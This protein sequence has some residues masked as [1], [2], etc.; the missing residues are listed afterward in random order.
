MQLG[1][2]HRINAIRHAWGHQADLTHQLQRIQRSPQ[3]RNQLVDLLKVETVAAINPQGRPAAA[4]A[5][6]EQRLEPGEIVE[7]VFRQGI[8][9]M[10]NAWDEAA[11]AA[12]GADPRMGYI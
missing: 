5:A 6:T 10:E 4:E 7:A 11:T 2:P 9:V 3:Q 12:N 8:D 1:N